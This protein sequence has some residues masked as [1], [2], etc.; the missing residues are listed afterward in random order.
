M[1]SL[2]LR[3]W[4][5]CKKLTQAVQDEQGQD[6]VE[7]SAVIELGRART[8]WRHEHPGQRHQH[9]YGFPQQ[10]DRQH[11]WV[12]LTLE[13][14]RTILSMSASSAPISACAK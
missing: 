8:D 9:G 3:L 5:K 7:Y 6:L 4:L 11:H 1:R 2:L 10:L 14:S 13:G 12:I